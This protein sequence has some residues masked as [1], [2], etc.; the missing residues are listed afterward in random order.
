[1]LEHLM[2]HVLLARLSILFLHL[3]LLLPPSAVIGTQ[4][5]GSSSASEWNCYDSLR[6][7]KTTLVELPTAY[8]VRQSNTHSHFNFFLFCGYRCFACVCICAPCVRS[9]GTGDMDGYKFLCGFWESN[10]ESLE[11]HQVL[12]TT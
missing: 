11:E 5:S 10:I 9:Q 6:S 1:M 12:L 3:S 2:I 7:V 4:T 8:N